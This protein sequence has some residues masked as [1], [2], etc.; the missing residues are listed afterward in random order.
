RAGTGVMPTSRM[1]SGLE[2]LF[3]PGLLDDPQLA[4]VLPAELVAWYRSDAGKWFA[5]NLERGFEGLPRDRIRGIYR[6]VGDRGRAAA[7]ALRGALGTTRPPGPTSG[8][9]PGYNGFLEMRELESAGI[10]PRAIFT[11]A[12]LSNAK[13]F[14]LADAGTLEVGKRA[15]LLLLERDP[16]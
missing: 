3:A 2:D 15:N 8:T 14:G 12:T 11:A 6:R 4:H 1:I 5:Q 13:R 10:A 9:P 16:L 7:A